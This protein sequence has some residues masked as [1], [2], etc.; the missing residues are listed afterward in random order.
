MKTYRCSYAVSC[1]TIEAS[2][3]AAFPSAVVTYNLIA[4]DYFEVRV[5][6]AGDLD[7]LDDIMAEFVWEG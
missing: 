2:I 4:E 6:F 3:R 7:E 1:D 5:I